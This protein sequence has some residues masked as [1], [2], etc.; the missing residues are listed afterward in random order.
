MDDYRIMFDIDG[1]AATVKFTDDA[2]ISLEGA[3]SVLIGHF[4][5]VIC[6]CTNSSE[7]ILT[8]IYRDGA[9][10]TFEKLNACKDVPN[11][12]HTKKHKRG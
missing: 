6:I 2:R 8:G 4:R 5:D 3:T 12:S 10:F 9:V 1:D 7:W 11:H